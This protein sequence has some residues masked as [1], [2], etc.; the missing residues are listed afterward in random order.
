MRRVAAS[1][2]PSSRSA[3]IGSPGVVAQQVQQ[4][5]Q[6]HVGQPVER[7]PRPGVADGDVADLPG[8]QERPP[9]V[10]Q[11]LGGR[12]R[13]RS[14]TVPSLSGTAA[15]AAGAA[16]RPARSAR[17]RCRPGPAATAARRPGCRPATRP[18]R[19]AALPAGV[20][21]RLGD[22]EHPGVGGDAGAGVTDPH[23]RRDQ[24]ASADRHPHRPGP[25]RRL[26]RVGVRALHDRADQRAVRLP[27]QVSACRVS[28]RPRASVARRPL[29][30]HAVRR[31]RGARRITRNTRP[32]SSPRAP[33]VVTSQPAS[34][35]VKV[36]RGPDTAAGLSARTRPA[37][38]PGSAPAG[39]QA[40]TR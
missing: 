29:E 26:L 14:R 40:S 2:G 16:A 5:A 20:G 11:R 22:L 15:G 36:R 33:T 8:L 13:R 32:Q 18:G 19:A 9:D 28:S 4:P 27:F 38:P 7:A 37:G 10:A 24:L 12:P 25:G 39:E 34:S 35:A 31:P 1:S 21:H 30:Q 23:H 3:N 17:R 6:P